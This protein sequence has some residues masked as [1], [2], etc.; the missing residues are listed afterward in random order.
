VSRIAR[1]SAKMVDG[2]DKNLTLQVRSQ[3]TYGWRLHAGV[4]AYRRYERGTPPPE[5]EP[6]PLDHVNVAAARE[7]LN[8]LGVP[9][10]S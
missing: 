7:E 9:M 1:I 2:M 10:T 6:F 8:E 4:K 3:G 5:P